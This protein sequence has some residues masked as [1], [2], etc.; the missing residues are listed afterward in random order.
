MRAHSFLPVMG[1]RCETNV[2]CAS[3]CGVA[4]MDRAPPEGGV[5]YCLRFIT[6]GISCGWPD[7]I[8]VRIPAHNTQ[9]KE[10][11]HAKHNLA[12]IAVPKA[13]MEWQKRGSALFVVVMRLC[14]RDEATS[15]FNLKMN[16]TLD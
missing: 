10:R 11:W 13:R 2:E 6:Q 14:A 3:S 5:E 15:L 8:R 1:D 9:R 16:M 7:V 12:A 4:Q